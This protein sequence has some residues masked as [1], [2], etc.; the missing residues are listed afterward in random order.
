MPTLDEVDRDPVVLRDGWPN[1]AETCPYVASM[2][3][4]WKNDT[5]AKGRHPWALSQAVRLA[6]ALRKGCVTT[7]DGEV[8]LDV[9]TKRYEALCRDGIGGESRKPDSM[10]G[11][12][13]WALALAECKT[14]A[15][16]DDELGRHSHE[17][18]GSPGDDSGY[19][20]SDLAD[21][22]L[23]SAA[24][25]RRMARDWHGRYIYVPQMGWHKWDGCRWAPVDERHLNAEAATWAEEFIIGLIR[26]RAPREVLNSALKYRDVGQVIALVR[27]ATTAPA[28]LVDVDALDAHPHL[29]NCP[30]GV[31]DLRDGSLRPSD[32][33]LY[34][35]KVTSVPFEP[36]YT[37]PDWDKALEALDREPREFLQRR[38]GQALYG[39]PPSSDEL[40]LCHGG[41]E[42][43]KTTVLA[44][45]YK[46]INDYAVMVPEEALI[47]ASDQH[48]TVF[49]VFRGARLALLEETPEARHINTV[50][51][52]RVVGQATMT[53]RLIGKDFVTFPITHSMFIATN[54]LP[55]VDETDHGT[56][57]RLLR[58]DFP[59]R[60][61]D[62]PVRPDD[63][64]G[65]RGLR[66]RI[67]AQGSGG[68]LAAL[69]WMV[70]GAV[71]HHEDGWLFP[72]PPPQ[73]VEATKD[74]RRQADTTW[75]F[76]EENLVFDQGACVLAQEL[77][78]HFTDWMKA[79]GMRDW[80]V[81]TFATRFGS[82]GLVQE[83]G[84]VKQETRELA[85]LSRC[86]GSLSRKAPPRATVW[87]G[88]R[89]RRS[90]EAPGE[91]GE[92]SSGGPSR[93]VSCEAPEASSPP[94]SPPYPGDAENV[95]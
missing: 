73:V 56:W 59:Y 22:Q 26:M 2:V 43:G 7:E 21:G 24:L 30:N 46:A 23:R 3:T 58:L 1:A 66:D 93:G 18:P 45:A 84:V 39:Q 35:T 8:A 74:W 4:G 15:E 67:N 28:L 57:R 42:N 94:S 69:A 85:G 62:D 68:L 76:I 55:T 11:K 25:G 32:P 92:G 86:P 49:M 41:G 51:L 5:P 53:G 75:A 10:V 20:H 37:H 95:F 33:S 78:E 77:F 6:C 52:K 70:A 79:R 38:L 34:L 44:A 87:L 19:G 88:V 12:W 27:G 29:L 83:A 9:L 82:H 72:P 89:F 64:Q 63:R 17:T 81:R 14:D 13:R 47:G 60:F 65:D 31:V 71:Q 16:V 91:G 90:D 40:L 80:N 50:R 36:G 48:P 61:C 54:Y